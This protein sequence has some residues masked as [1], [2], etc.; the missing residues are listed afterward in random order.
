MRIF[1]GWLKRHLISL[2]NA[3]LTLLAILCL[4]SFVTLIFALYQHYRL[5]AQ[6]TAKIVHWS[7]EENSNN[8]FVIKAEY[9][10]EV[11][12]QL[13]QGI[14]FFDETYRHPLAAE[15]TIKKYSSEQLS[16]WFNRKNP[17]FSSLAKELPWKL[18]IRTI[19]LIGILVY[20]FALCFWHFKNGSR[21]HQI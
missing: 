4:W 17:H 12:Q 8:Y 16:V 14:F 19:V 18:I 5:D 3:F 21:D 2:Q 11:D 7:V 13:I 20:F 10:F 6:H 9:E 1:V 15:R